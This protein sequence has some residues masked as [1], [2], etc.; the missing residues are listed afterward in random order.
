MV[1]GRSLLLSIPHQFLDYGRVGEGGGISQLF[2]ALGDSLEDPSHDLAGSG[3]GQGIGEL[4]LVWSGDGTDLFAHVFG[5]FLSEFFGWFLV[6]AEGDEG[7][8]GLAFDFVGEGDDSG[9]GDQGVADEGAFD[10]HGAD[11]VA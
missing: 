4:D 7:I 11:A 3:L 1:Q 6:T 5:Q 9:L 2:S 8:E 10:L